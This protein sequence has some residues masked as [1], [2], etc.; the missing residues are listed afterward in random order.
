M[1]PPSASD[2]ASLR[3]TLYS[4]LTLIARLSP[5]IRTTRTPSSDLAPPSNALAL[6]ASAATLTKA[7]VTKLSL[8]ALNK[9]FSPREIAFVLKKLSSECM[10]ALVIA[11]QLCLPTQYGHCVWKAVC[12]GVED[13]LRELAGLVHDVPVDERG[14][15]RARG[16]DTLGNT[17][18]LWGVCDG[19]IALGE[20]GVRGV[21]GKRVEESRGLVVDAVG[22]LEGWLEDGADDL[23][24]RVE[25]LE[26]EGDED[27][28]EDEDMF[29]EAK[30]ASK[31]I[32]LL[33]KK[34][35]EVLKLLALLYPALVKRRV[36]R[37]PEIHAKVEVDGFP[38]TRLIE[39]LDGLVES[40]HKLSEDADELAGALYAG[41]EGVVEERL[42]TLRAETRRVAERYR[43]TWEGGED[44]FSAWVGK[45]MVRLDEL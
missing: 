7:Q 40:T 44:E 8:L 13:G 41:D 17:G 9:P 33:G 11:A 42:K 5:I 32:R 26:L 31:A 14:V 19:L 20:E 43:K 10:P 29:G 34:S 6:L 2:L 35:V 38:S 36:K 12:S 16:R 3:T 25:G 1:P 37:F 30:P 27:E 4:T 28:D 45:W 39:E 21:A 24:E 18:V 23:A 15:E 22:E